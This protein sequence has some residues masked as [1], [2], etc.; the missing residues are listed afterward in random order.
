M[1]YNH[2]HTSK[3]NKNIPQ[4]YD[5]YSE[6]DDNNQYYNNQYYSNHHNKH[7]HTHQNDEYDTHNQHY[8]PN[9]H[10]SHK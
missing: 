8:T 6:Y 1:H 2:I 7:A 5:K 10:S 4:K 3:L 9:H